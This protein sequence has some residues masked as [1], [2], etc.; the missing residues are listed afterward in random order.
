MLSLM[1]TTSL[2]LLPN[3]PRA[4]AQSNASADA[5]AKATRTERNGWLYLHLE[6]TPDEIGYQH[7]WLLAREIEDALRVFKKYL[8]HVNGAR[9]WSV[10]SQRGARDVLE[11]DRRRVSKE[12]YK[13]SRAAR[14]RA[15]YA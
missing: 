11:Q 3:L 4:A 2:L 1:I 13:V 7:G 8:Q 10:L 5:L 6:G 15:A 9:R 14:M 12:R